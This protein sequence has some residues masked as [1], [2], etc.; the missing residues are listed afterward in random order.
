MRELDLF[1]EKERAGHGFSPIPDQRSTKPELVSVSPASKSELQLHGPPAIVNP[2][3]AS[4]NRRRLPPLHTAPIGTQSKLEVHIYASPA[5][6]TIGY[7]RYEVSERHRRDMESAVFQ[8]I[9]IIGKGL[10][11]RFSCIT[12]SGTPSQYDDLC[13]SLT[14]PENREGIGSSFKNTKN[15]LLVEALMWKFSLVLHYFPYN[16]GSQLN[17]IRALIEH[18]VQKKEIG[19][20]KDTAKSNIWIEDIRAE[21]LKKILKTMV[22][23]C[24]RHSIQIC[25]CGKHHHEA[26]DVNSSGDMSTSTV[27]GKKPLR[28]ADEEDDSN[29]S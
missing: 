3:S 17:S 23:D 13:I 6:R 22:L 7:D 24:A 25:A 27:V 28:E 26:W 10:N 19:L 15:Y 29:L 9:E 8:A 21:Q 4:Q 11:P 18:V 20:S 12:C 14:Q 1:C 16:T 2:F 5:V